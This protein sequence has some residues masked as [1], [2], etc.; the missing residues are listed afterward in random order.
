[1]V[2]AKP[3]I[4]A[5]SEH[6]GFA[7]P[8][9]APP[10]WVG[11]V[12][13]T[14]DSFSDGGRFAAAG[15]AIAHGRDLMAAGAD[16]IDVGGESTRPGAQPVPAAV[17]IARVV[18]VIEALA[19]AGQRPISVD[20]TKAEVA[21]AAIAAGAT[22]VNDISGGRFDPAMWEVCADAGVTYVCGHVP[23]A[24]LAEV[25]GQ[26]H[27]LSVAAITAQ[28][29]ATLAA[30]PPAL[31]ARTVVDPGLGFGKGP[32]LN[33]AICARAGDLRAALGRPVMVGPSRK[34][35]IGALSGQPVAARDAT[36]AGVA[37]AAAVA[38]ADFIRVHDVALSR[39][40]AM[41]FAACAR[42]GDGAEVTA[43]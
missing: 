42:A 38:G 37:I 20:T 33:L 43:R 3:E 6:A 24:T 9:G 15:A 4:S 12:N 31:V 11:I 30:M 40:A 13:V 21:R 35:F 29:A 23:G 22:W 1:M 34:R 10:W 7:F 5:R 39:S 28:L 41:A 25:H 26:Y 2:G 16:L 18:P 36:S 19:A 17:E 32:D 27:P 8:D 14:P